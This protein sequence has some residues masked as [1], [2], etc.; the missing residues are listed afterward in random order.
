MSAPT[1][2]ATAPRTRTRLSRTA[3]RGITAGVI[4]AVLVGMALG[5]RVVPLDDPLAQ[6]IVEFNAADFGAE[7]FEIVQEGIIDR[8]ADA[9]V[10]AAAIA[11]DPE[12]AADQYAVP[13]SGGPVF[14]VSFTGVVGDGQSGIYEIQVDG[15]PDDLLVR[16]QTGPAIN[17]TE[18]R[19]ATGAYEFGE[20]TNQIAFQNAAAA[21][22]DELKTRVLE[23]VDT[24]NLSGQTV[25]V[26]G[27]FTL[28]NPAAWLVTPVEVTVL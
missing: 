17:G 7:Q 9:T 23:S 16:L 4:A 5:T 14:S 15:L 11:D 18:L 19:D 2:S 8:S 25:T 20:F 3:K 1:T 27:A 10:V 24:D 21:L 13:S 28:V 22:N 6:G 26:V 12:A